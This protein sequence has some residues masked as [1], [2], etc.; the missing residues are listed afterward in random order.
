MMMLNAGGVVEIGSRATMRLYV[1]SLVESDGSRN[2]DAA[3]G[4][5]FSVEM[6]PAL[7]NTK[8]PLPAIGF[9]DAARGGTGQ[10]LRPS[11]GRL[12]FA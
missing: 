5:C 1:P 7:N 6:N 9:F 10:L 11:D 12:P 3:R 2:T 4:W 8:A